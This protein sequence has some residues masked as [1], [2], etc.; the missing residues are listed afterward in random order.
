MYS[1]GPPH[2][3]EQRLD[4]QLEPIQRRSV[5]I[6]DVACNTRREQWTIES[7]GGRRPGKFVPAAQHD[8]NH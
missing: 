3:D 8:V 7:G 6:S 2:M 1:N 5:P 4:D